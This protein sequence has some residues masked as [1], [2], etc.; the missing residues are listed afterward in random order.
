MFCDEVAPGA[1]AVLDLEPTK[2]AQE[3]STA[4]E[5]RREI[6]R[7]SERVIRSMAGDY[8]RTSWNKPE[9]NQF[10]THVYEFLRIMVPQM[11]MNNPKVRVSDMGITDNSTEALQLGLE[12]VIHLN[13]LAHTLV[14]M[15]VDNFIDFT[16]GMVCLEPT[17]G[18]RGDRSPGAFTPKFPAIKRVS[19]RLYFRDPHAPLHERPRF[20]GHLWVKDRRELLALVE[21]DELNGQE[22]RFDAE[23]LAALPSAT[24]SSIKED[25]IADGLVF[26][27]PTEQ[28]VGLD[29]FVHG[30]GELLECAYA[31][32]GDLRVLRRAR[33]YRGDRS[34]PYHL[35]RGQLRPPDQVY[36]L[37]ALAATLKKVDEYNTHR[38]KADNDAKKAKMVGITS[39]QDRVITHK[40]TE[41]DSHSII[42]VPGFNGQVQFVTFPGVMPE[43]AQWIG[44]IQQELERTSAL[45]A[46]MRGEISTDST[47]REV[48]EAAGYA[49]V[50]TK[51]AE[52]RFTEDVAVLLQKAVSLMDNNPDVIFPLAAVDPATGKKMR[53]EFRG[54]DQD[55]NDVY[56]WERSL[57]VTIEP[58]SMPYTRADV[59]ARQTQDAQ[60]YVLKLLQVE[61]AT[62]GLK[63]EAMMNDVLDRI[64][65]PDGADRYVDWNARKQ[66][67]ASALMARQQQ[68][69]A[70]A[71]PA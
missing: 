64:N 30:T 8:Y 50:Q 23:V 6:T 9:L 58:Y 36:P 54:E 34:G 39:G 69:L 59:L 48:S 20:E 62:P 24:L 52:A 31:G 53:A 16:V 22:P 38:A 26:H 2:L 21:E 12:S 41:A 4:L 11:V 10:C 3:I 19:P 17:P 14:D 49:D 25:L 66:L 67:L 61:Q 68:Q 18:Y 63:A 46:T 37:S 35:F 51:S 7:N 1:G 13:R 65:I 45:T 57:T 60:A 56:P 27:D 42:S 15:A 5:L 70:A 29:V 40:L 47:A 32:E 71:V 55:P 28:V 43:T 33:K 44:N